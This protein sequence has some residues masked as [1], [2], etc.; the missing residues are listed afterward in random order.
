MTNKIVVRVDCFCG[1]RKL[2]TY[3][4]PIPLPLD[5]RAYKLLPPEDF[6]AQAKEN[7]TTDGLAF[8]PYSGITFKIEY[9]K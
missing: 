4:F 2:T 3:D 9:L 1:A 7:I 6:E 5:S 8:Y